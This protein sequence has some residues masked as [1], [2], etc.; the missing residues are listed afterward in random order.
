MTLTERFL[1]EIQTLPDLLV[2]LALG[3]SAFVENIFPPIPG[4]TVTAF[5]AFLVGMGKLSFFGVYLS[6]TLGSLIGFLS[7]YWVGRYLD[8][9]FFLKRNYRFLKAGDI[10]KAEALFGKYGYF[11]VGLNRFLP[12][13]RSVI[14]LTAG[15]LR[16]NTARVALLALISCSVWN[17]IWMVLGHSLGTHWEIIQK[18]L[19]AIMTK[20]NIVIVILMGLLVSAFVIR[21]L[22]SKGNPED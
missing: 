12:G 1:Y 13:V 15:I 2:Y 11:L 18:R 3:L 4:D 8:R 21:K 6:T 22:V 19:A 14:S 16:L 10:L 9:R 20:Y 5:G 7:L 17:L